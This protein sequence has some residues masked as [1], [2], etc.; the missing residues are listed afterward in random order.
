MDAAFDP[1][2][3]T[4]FWPAKINKTAAGFEFYKLLPSEWISLP[5]LEN[6]TSYISGFQ[7]SLGIRPI[8]FLSAAWVAVAGARACDGVVYDP[9][10]SRMYGGKEMDNLL[11]QASI[12][13]EESTRLMSRP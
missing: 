6:P 2:K 11:S 3:D 10:E 7:F 5:N 12:W 9:Q 1:V 4:G 8:E 13:F